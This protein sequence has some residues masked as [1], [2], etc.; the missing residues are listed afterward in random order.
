MAPPRQ[1]SA[2][3]NCLP[4]STQSYQSNPDQPQLPVRVR[5]LRDGKLVYMAVP[6]LA[7]PLPFFRLDP[8]EMGDEAE[9]LAAR[10]A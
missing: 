8:G 7:H 3:P 9:A 6:K 10:V 4:G 1:P 5:A 2:L